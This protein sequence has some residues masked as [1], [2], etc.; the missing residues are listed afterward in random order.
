METIKN[1]SYYSDIFRKTKRHLFFSFIAFSLLAIVF[2]LIILTVAL[3]NTKHYLLQLIFIA[4]TLILITLEY[5][6][7]L[8]PIFKKLKS[9]V[10]ELIASEKESQEKAKTLEH[11]NSIQENSLQELKEINYA[12][13]NTALFV[14]I[15][16]EGDTVFMSQKFQRLLGLTKSDI[17]GAVEHLLTTNEGQRIYLKELIKNRTR[18]HTEALEIT[19]ESN[20]KLW[21][22]ISIIPLNRISLQQK[23]LILCSNITD[24]KHNEL[25]L[26][27]ISKEKYNEE[28]LLQQTI[29]SQIIDAQENERERIAKDIHDGI[30]QMLT[31]LKFHVEGINI[32]NP[33]SAS[34]KIEDLKDISKEL[35]QGVRMATFNLTPPELTDHGIASA[36]QTLAF[37]L[38]KLTGKEIIFTN[39]SNFNLRLDSLTEINLYRITQE[40]V[41]NAIKYAKSDFILVKLNHSQELLSISIEDNGKGFDYQETL[42]RKNK[43]MGLLFMEER[44]KY[45][46]GRLF[47][48]S[49]KG[50]G[51]KITLNTPIKA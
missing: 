8:K 31:G 50:A 21:L 10:T 16:S 38:A 3:Q 20:A 30:G 42:K 13:D 48:N 7:I 41:N 32:N 15:N 6:F 39:S 24:K 35:I 1:I 47:I 37:K 14:S 36:L 12:I 40:A 45:I 44:I 19:T 49:E 4:S 23:T 34:K 46:N 29:S 43:G 22:N 17:S 27:R 33:E 51:T 26:D 25:E 18:I 9:I 28:I 2:Q 11:L 5:I